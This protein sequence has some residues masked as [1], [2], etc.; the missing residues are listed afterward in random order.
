MPDPALL[1]PGWTAATFEGLRRRQLQEFRA[2]PFTDK[3][4]WLEEADEVVA[5]F[6]R[7]RAA[8][9]QRKLIPLR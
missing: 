2:L 1:T 8:R 4:A 3:L 9:E 7:L 5:L 6:A